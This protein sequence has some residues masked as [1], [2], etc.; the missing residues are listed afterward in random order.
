VPASTGRRQNLGGEALAQRLTMAFVQ[1]LLALVSRSLGRIVG[2]L[3]GWAVV[4]LFGATSSAE[5]I[6]LSALVGAAAAWPILILGIIWPRA[7]TLVLALVPIPAAIPDWAIRLAWVLL[8]VL[9]PVAVGVTLATRSRGTG[10]LIPGTPGPPPR[11]PLVESRLKRLLRGLPV[12]AA[13]AIAFFIV[14]VSV[15]AQRIAAI[16]RRRTDVQVPLVTDARAYEVVAAEIARTL[17]QHGVPV[18]ACEPPW[19]LAAPGR[20]L[21]RLGGPSFHD[22]VPER[23]AFFRDRRLDA[24]LYPTSLLLRGPAQETAWAHGILVEALSDAPA[25]QTFDADAQ[26]VE[27]QIRSVWKT[28]QRH[29]DAHEGSPWLER[30][31]EEIAHDI[32][33]L[34]VTYDEWQIVY[35]QALQL[36]RALRGERQLLEQAEPPARTVREEVLMATHLVNGDSTRVQA[37][38]TRELLGEIVEKAGLLARK[39]VELA[40]TELKADLKSQLGMAKGLGIAGLAG[41]LGVN[42]LLVAVVLA[43]APLVTPWLGALILGGILV[44]GGGIVAWVS[45]KRRVSNPLALTRKSLKEDVQWAKEHLA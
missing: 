38:P 35:R 17:H 36:G 31:L 33:A 40:K 14:F 15:P 45:W 6:R 30:R 29:P 27:R 37:L 8:A 1:A 44:V 32:R 20:I 10:R 18:V 34:P 43:L 19:W 22:Y 11:T 28:Y 7:A 2:A 23:L 26:D 25:Y 42:L 21:R 16:A 39:E 9:V 4:A 5:K 3:F 12:T 41:L 13:I 24:V